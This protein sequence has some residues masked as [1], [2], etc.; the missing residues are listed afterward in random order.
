MCH[1]FGGTKDHMEGIVAGM[2]QGELDEF[3]RTLLASIETKQAE[4]A[5]AKRQ[6]LGY[7]SSSSSS[8]SSSLSKKIG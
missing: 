7:C 1:K 3:K 6:K 8:S 4:D 5:A 2:D